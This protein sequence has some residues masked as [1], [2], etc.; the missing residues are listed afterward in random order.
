V[1]GTKD[2]TIEVIIC[3]PIVTAVA[4]P[5]ESSSTIIAALLRQA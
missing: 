2:E 1:L 5:S 4:Q 3:K